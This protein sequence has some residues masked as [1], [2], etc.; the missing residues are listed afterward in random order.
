MSGLLKHQAKSVFKH[1]ILL[2][3]LCK[4]LIATM[5]INTTPEDLKDMDCKK[6]HVAQWPPILFMPVT[7]ILK[8]SILAVTIKVKLNASGND[9]CL[10]VFEDRDN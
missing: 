7:S 1:L 3:P 9:I 6:G 10:G 5:S 2:M 8:T 4:H